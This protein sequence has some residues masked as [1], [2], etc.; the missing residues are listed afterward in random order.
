MLTKLIGSLVVAVA[1]F[2]SGAFLVKGNAAPNA[3][4]PKTALTKG[5][6]CAEGAK[7]CTPP[8]ECC[9]VEDCCALGLDCC[10]T[11]ESCCV[12]K[13]AVMAKATTKVAKT[14]CCAVGADCCFPPQSCCAAK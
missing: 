5:S 4:T 14:D 7:C 9:F 1:L 6:C 3:A 2:V 11:G 12:D 8:S 13:T 10:A